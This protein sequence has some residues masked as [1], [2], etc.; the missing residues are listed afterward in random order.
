[1]HVFRLP[2]GCRYYHSSLTENHVHSE[3]SLRFTFYVLRFTFYVD[4]LFL[5]I[6]SI[7][8]A[9]PP[10]RPSSYLNNECN[11]FFLFLFPSPFSPIPFLPNI[12][13]IK[14]NINII[15]VYL[16]TFNIFNV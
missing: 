11:P 14:V 16:L 6:V 2:I 1:M 8:W 9:T 4:Y 3:Y 12:N 13:I 10:I 7:V 5:P 15:K